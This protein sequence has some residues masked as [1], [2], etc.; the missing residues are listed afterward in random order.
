MYYSLA[1]AGSGYSG[2]AL[3]RI[4]EAREL[5]HRLNQRAC[6]IV[7]QS[8][9]YL[10]LITMADWPRVREHAIE[11]IEVTRQTNEPMAEMPARDA[12]AWAQSHLGDA[13]NAVLNR[14]RAAA[15]RRTVRG[16]F[17]PDWFEAAEAEILL[18][19]GRTEDALRHAQEVAAASRAA[20]QL[21]SLAIAERNIG[22]ALGRLGADRAEAEAHLEESIAISRSA[23]QVMNEA[24]GELCLGQL[25]RER[26]DERS[27]Q[28]HFT[29]AMARMEAGGFVYAL[30]RARA[31][32]AGTE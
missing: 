12:L 15:A 19:A 1:L 5:T 8:L 21:F 27:A 26:G 6:L 11:S 2:E 3:A 23:E 30:D 14:E 28:A 9:H 32:A 13:A 17:L 29:R 25:L 20:E 24:Q 31:I 16:G 7:F 10:V 4:E 18:H 22:V